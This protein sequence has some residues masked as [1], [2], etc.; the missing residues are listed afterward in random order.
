MMAE[1]RRTAA[2]GIALLLLAA[3]CGRGGLIEI[4][5]T[6]TYDGQPIQKGCITLL[7]LKG[8]GPTAA[9]IVKDGKYTVRVAPGQ[10]RVQIEGY[11]ILGQR[12]S[13]QSC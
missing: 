9:A 6:V 12:R 1:S 8:D 3:G 10:K 13:Q 7:P 11:K 4:T 2:C 5:G